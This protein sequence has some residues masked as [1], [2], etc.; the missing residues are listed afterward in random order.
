MLSRVDVALQQPQARAH[1][2]VMLACR[3][4]HV[5]CSWDQCAAALQALCI[6]PTRE[7]V[8]QNLQVL[9][10]MAKY[11]SIT[12][13]STATGSAEGSRQD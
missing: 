2:S 9:S 7:L 13:V 5:L 11:T 1:F 12:A 10:R 3:R 4:L 6:C 8:I